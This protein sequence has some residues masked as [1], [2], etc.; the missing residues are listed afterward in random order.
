MYA[1]S[2]YGF[3]VIMKQQKI[4]EKEID[5]LLLFTILGVIV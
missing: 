2:F 3:Y 1:M 4:S 5:T